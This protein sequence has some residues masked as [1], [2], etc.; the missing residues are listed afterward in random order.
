MHVEPMDLNIYA[1]D[2]YYFNYDNAA[3]KAIWERVLNART[4]DE[5][6]RLLGEAQRR[7]TEDAVNVYL[8][9]RPEQNLMHRD[10]EGMWEKSPIPSFVLEDIRWVNQKR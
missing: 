1:R 9:M 2:D 3:F 7:I 4:E 6:H 8:F 5:L 10:L